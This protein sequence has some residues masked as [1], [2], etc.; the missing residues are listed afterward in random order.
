MP[1]KEYTPSLLDWL[2]FILSAMWSPWLVI[3]LVDKAAKKVREDDAV[4]QNITQG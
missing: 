1:D 4:N 3:I 2:A